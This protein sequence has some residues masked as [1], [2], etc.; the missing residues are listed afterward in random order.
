M[1]RVHLRWHSYMRALFWAKKILG[2]P[3][4]ATSARPTNA[5]GSRVRPGKTTRQLVDSVLRPGAR[6]STRSISNACSDREQRL[7]ITPHLWPLEHMCNLKTSSAV[8][9]CKRKSETACS[10][11][12]T[13]VFRYSRAHS[14]YRKAVEERNRTNRL[15]SNVHQLQFRHGIVHT[16]PSVKVFSFE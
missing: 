16:A 15:G 14:L 1:I 12:Y 8:F 13:V 11:S 9:R 2:E 5:T 3:I 10:T 4:S 7:P 6:V